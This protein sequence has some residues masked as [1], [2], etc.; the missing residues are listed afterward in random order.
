MRRPSACDMVDAVTDDIKNSY[1]RSPE[2]PADLLEP[3]LEVQRFEQLTLAATVTGPGMRT[4]D[5]YERGA[6]VKIRGQRGLFTYRYASVSQAG[7][8]SLHLAGEDG[9][10][11]VRPDQVLPVR[12]A[13]TRK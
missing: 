4:E 6:R 13:R 12:K 8:V 3:S 9:C 5:H 11:A 7:Q 2:R 1:H 10:R